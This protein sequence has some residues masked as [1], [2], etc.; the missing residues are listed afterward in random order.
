M[1]KFWHHLQLFKSSTLL[2]SLLV[3]LA[4]AAELGAQQFAKK[5][6]KV[7]TTWLGTILW[8][9]FTWLL[10]FKR[11]SNGSGVLLI[12]TI[13]STPIL[14]CTITWPDS[15]IPLVPYK[16]LQKVA[17]RW[18]KYKSQKVIKS[19][20]IA[21]S[22][23]KTWKEI[24]WILFY[25]SLWCFQLNIHDGC[26]LNQTSYGL[27]FFSKLGNDKEAWDQN[28]AK[29]NNS[30]NF[31]SLDGGSSKNYVDRIFAFSDHLPPLSGHRRPFFW[32]VVVYHV[33]YSRH[34]AD[35]LPTSSCPRSFWMTPGYKEVWGFL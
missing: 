19:Q 20:K 10:L 22:H 25:Y 34:F 29:G 2:H 15:S 31:S 23:N 21:K 30:I 27:K 12:L 13:W 35:H 26:K 1:G 5:K 24:I 28:D 18:K 8:H 3:H 6:Q 32:V 16:K 4:G 11:S 17:K 14:T 33:T 9:L 7:R